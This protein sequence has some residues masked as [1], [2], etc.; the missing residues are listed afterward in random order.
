MS[1]LTS[2][3]SLI[4]RTGRTTAW[5][6]RSWAGGALLAVPLWAAAV[7]GVHVRFDL[8]SPATSPFP[9]DRFTRVDWGQKTFK[10][11][12]LPK[13]DCTVR[14]SDCADIDVINQ[15]DGFNTQPRITIPFSG[16]IDPASVTSDTVYLVNLGDTQSGAGFGQ[17]VG[18]NQVVWDGATKTLAVESDALLAEHS[19][20]VLVVT[21]GVRDAQG[22]PIEAGPYGRF[23][24]EFARS[25]DRDEADYGKALSD[26][27]HVSG[28]PLTRIAALS[29]FTT[30]STT[31]DLEKIRSQ[32]KRSQ[33]AP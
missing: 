8:A 9:S 2:R 16:D 11:V 6:W 14:P 12:N 23:R 5:R 32:I 33:P 20:Y 18:I 10:R 4:P 19:R 13:P 29:L 7:P 15:L 17:R 31:A 28:A 22:R 21:T 30:Q 25:R 26:G 3:C 27:S 1:S 24:Q